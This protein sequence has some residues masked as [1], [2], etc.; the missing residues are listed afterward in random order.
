MGSS[1]TPGSG[2]TAEDVIKLL[3][4]DRMEAT[5]ENGVTAQ[6]DPSGAYGCKSYRSFIIGITPCHSPTLCK[7]LSRFWVATMKQMF[8]K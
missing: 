1:P 2:E 8:S 3:Y 6:A 5:L 7:Y 4:M